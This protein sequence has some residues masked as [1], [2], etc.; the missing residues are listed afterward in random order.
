MG[1]PGSTDLSASIG[2]DAF[3]GGEHVGRAMPKRTPLPSR[4]PSARRGSASGALSGRARSSQ[5]RWTPVMRPSE[6]GDGGEQRRPDFARRAF[7]RAVL[8]RR[9]EAQA[10]PVERRGDAARAQIGL[11]RRADDRTAGAKQAAGG[12]WRV[13]GAAGGSGGRT[14]AGTRQSQEPARLVERRRGDGR[15][16]RLPAIRSSRSPC[17][18]VAASVLCSTAHKTEYVAPRVMLR[19]CDWALFREA[20]DGFCAT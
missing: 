20:I 13:A 17:S 8:D 18:P 7:V 14:P 9:M 10:R 1:R 19:P 2:L 15:R 11:G 4:W 16:P 12:L 3:A 6:V 5:V